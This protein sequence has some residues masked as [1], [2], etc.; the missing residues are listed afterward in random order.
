MGISSINDQAV[1]RHEAEAFLETLDSMP[2]QAVTACRGWTTH[3]VV[4]HLTSGAEALANQVEAKLHGQPVPPFGSW[5]EREPPYR[6]LDDGVLRQRFVR[7][8]GRMAA[9]FTEMLAHD[10]AARYDDVG[11][12]FP[13]SELVNHMRQEFAIHRWDLI[14]DDSLGDT[15]MSQPELLNH[16]VRMLQVPL[17]ERGRALDPAPSAP[18]DIR[19]SAGGTDD[20]R[21]EVRRGET[22]L[23]LVPPDGGGEA[24][25]KVETDPAARLLLLWGRRPSD[26]SRVRSQLE[27][28]QLFRLQTLL[29]GY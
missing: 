11:F 8:E 24:T 23:S 15:L 2:P 26:A 13:V 29:S 16:S 1:P 20:L 5:E 12:G 18:L 4:A 9:A 7:A 21:I 27:A 3:E 10:S 28:D 17:L 25:V 19:I 6:A 14:G 22:A